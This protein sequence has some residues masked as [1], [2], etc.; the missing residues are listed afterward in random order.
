MKAY[1]IADKYKEMR[2]RDP[3]LPIIGQKLNSNS[4]GY[5]I[6]EQINLIPSL[7]NFCKLFPDSILA[8][9]H[10]YWNCKCLTIYTIANNQVFIDNH[11]LEN[12]NVGPYEIS[13]AFSFSETEIPNNITRF[14]NRNYP[15]EFQLNFIK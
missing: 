11:N 4:T 15:Q 14:F 3:Y 10:F 2:I 9:Y 13:S 5:G 1:D 12:M 7:L 8:F 6:G